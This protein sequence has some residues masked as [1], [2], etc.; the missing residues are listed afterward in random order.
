ME[1]HCVDQR[2]SFSFLIAGVVVIETLSI[3]IAAFSF[4]QHVHDEC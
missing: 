1:F 4:E 2:V 3:S